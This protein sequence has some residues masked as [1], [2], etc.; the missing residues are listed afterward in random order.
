[1]RLVVPSSYS[2]ATPAPILVVYRGTE[3]GA[4]K[5][6]NLMQVASFTGT[7]SFVEAVLD[8]VVY[9]GNGDAG[10]TVLDKVRALYNVDNDRAYVLG[11][12]AGTPAA[13]KLGF[14]LR[15]SYFAAYWA[16]DVN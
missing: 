12:S 6:M 14:H 10:V 9:N 4:R 13:E 5:T 15:E 2:P 11:E 1:Y 8:G 7:S 16:N 3:G